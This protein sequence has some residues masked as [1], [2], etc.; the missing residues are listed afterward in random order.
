[1]LGVIDPTKEGKEFL[2]NRRKSDDAD[3]KSLCPV[4]QSGPLPIPGRRPAAVKQG[5]RQEPSR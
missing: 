2:C 5:G 1:M 3:T 4:A